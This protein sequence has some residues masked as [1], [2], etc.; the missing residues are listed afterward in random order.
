L[1]IDGHQKM[2]YKRRFKPLQIRTTAGWTTLA[3][4]AT[5][6]TR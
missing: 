3:S 4:Q 5:T 1:W 6:A 2:D